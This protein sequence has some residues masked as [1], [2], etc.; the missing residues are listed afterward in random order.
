MQSVQA[1]NTVNQVWVRL[2]GIDW[3]AECCRRNEESDFQHWFAGVTLMLSLRTSSGPPH[4]RCNASPTEHRKAKQNDSART[5][6][7][8]ERISALLSMDRVSH[9]RIR[10]RQV[11]GSAGKS[12]AQVKSVVS[13]V[14]PVQYSV[15]IQAPCA[16]CTACSEQRSKAGPAMVATKASRCCDQECRPP[17]YLSSSAGLENKNCPVESP[18]YIPIGFSICNAKQRDQ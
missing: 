16:V 17:F 6:T 5:K 13:T 12:L 4:G 10:C 9:Q 11:A 3:A 2:R 18:L 14:L 15:T 7:K 8:H 1:A